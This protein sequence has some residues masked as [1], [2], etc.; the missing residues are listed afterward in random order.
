MDISGGMTYTY[1]KPLIQTKLPSGRGGAS[2]VYA[3]GKVITF[4]GH[5]YAGDDKFEYLDETWILDTQS[6]AWHKIK[7]A[8]EA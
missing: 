2:V 8:R 4:G 7:V 5:F 1:N 3:D 6:L